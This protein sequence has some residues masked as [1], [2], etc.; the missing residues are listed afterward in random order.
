MLTCFWRLSSQPIAVSWI[1]ANIERNQTLGC[2]SGNIRA[3]GLM[4]GEDD[5]LESHQFDV[6]LCSD[7]VYGH[8]DISQKLV[9]TIV[10]LSHPDTLIVS[11]HEARFAG[12]R[13]ESFFALL[14]EQQF[15]IEQVSRERL[16][17]VYS[18]ANMHVHLIRP[19]LRNF[20]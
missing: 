2:I 7:L 11:A 15:Q 9:Q 8:R 3:Q 13:G 19:P 1:Q 18:A 10:H 20:K 17:A 4:W 5:D 6:I 16:D 12:D 14:S